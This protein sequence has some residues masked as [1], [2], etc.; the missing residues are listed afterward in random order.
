MRI[1]DFDTH[2]DERGK[3]TAIESGWTA[4][5]GGIISNPS[6]AVSFDIKRI[7]YIYDVPDGMERAGHGHEKCAQVL[8][9]LSGQAKVTLDG[10]DLHLCSPE[11]GI[12]VEPGECVRLHSFVPGT[13]ILVLCSEHYDAEDYFDCKG[14]Q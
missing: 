3:L 9:A 14:V 8:I 6:S 5:P 4:M 12:L 7:F 13:V 2:T 10:K 1:I 11:Y